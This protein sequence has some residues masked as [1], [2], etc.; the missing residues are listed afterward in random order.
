MKRPTQLDVAKRAGVSR[1]TVSFVLNGVPND[2]VPISLATK[3]RVLKAIADLGYEPD[4]RA[5]A[6][7]SGATKTIAFVIT[8]IRNPHYADYVIGIEEIAVENGYHLLISNTDL[9]DEGSLINFRDLTRQRID[10]LI[11]ASSFIL[12]SSEANALLN[13]LVKRKFP[14]V[15]L[16]GWYG[17][18][19]ALS[20]YQD[21]TSEV[22]KYLLDLGHRRIGMVY[23]VSAHEHAKDRLLPYLDSQHK[24]GLVVDH[25]LLVEC[26]PT[27]ED[28]YQAAARLLHHPARP[29]AIIAVNDLLAI[30]VY[31]A[32][33]DAGLQIPKD[34]SVVG[35]D[36]IP[37][38][39]Y[40]VP[41]LTTVSK[42]AVNLGKKAF[43]LLLTRIQNPDYP[44][45]RYTVPAK[46]IIRDS[47]GE[48][49]E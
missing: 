48:A 11:L 31:R 26:G 23:G 47:T 29:T 46:L 21:A 8:D 6:L 14:I 13:Q 35:Y 19:G 49:P 41:R 15:E 45:Q 3:Q 33:A 16:S 38:S 25:S 17:V 4:A 36:N 10:G 1:S 43:E 7:R 28:G 9:N 22:M 30:G 27:I 40:M 2:R 37:M 39:N 34:L 20:D 42:D 12:E 44:L 24:A 32:A 18:D 5:Q